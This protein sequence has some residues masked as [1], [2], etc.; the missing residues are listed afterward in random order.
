MNN[1]DLAGMKN[2]LA[3]E[4]YPNGESP[5]EFYNRIYSWFMDFLYHIVKN[6]EWNNKKSRLRWRIVVCMF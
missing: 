5:V 1:G 2:D 4:K 3:E 6:I